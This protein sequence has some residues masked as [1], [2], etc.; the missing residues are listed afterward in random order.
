MYSHE[1]IMA[2]ESLRIMTKNQ[3]FSTS[4][5]YKVLYN[6]DRDAAY[7]LRTAD[8]PEKVALSLK[9]RLKN[10][11]HLSPEEFQKEMEDV[12][13]YRWTFCLLCPVAWLDDGIVG[14]QPLL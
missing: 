14:C 4:L 8:T 10:A 5:A 1:D 3:P 12:A 9:E 2:C 11:E 6:L 13:D 7:D